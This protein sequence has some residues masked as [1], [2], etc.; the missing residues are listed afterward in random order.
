M[1][2][3]PSSLPISLPVSLPASLDRL[4]FPGRILGQRPVSLVKTGGGSPPPAPLSSAI[5]A[6]QLP[7]GF[8]H[9]CLGI[10]GAGAIVGE[11]VHH[12]EVGNRGCRLLTDLADA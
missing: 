4:E 6:L 5:D 9:R 7:F 8:R 3:M 2:A 1:S 11:H 12:D 10:L